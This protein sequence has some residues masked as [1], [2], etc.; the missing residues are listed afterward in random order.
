MGNFGTLAWLWPL[1]ASAS[2]YKGSK[3][4]F[5]GWAIISVQLLIDRVPSCHS[6]DFWDFVLNLAQVTDPAEN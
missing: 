4:G 5:F 1:M 3:L 2:E 6:F